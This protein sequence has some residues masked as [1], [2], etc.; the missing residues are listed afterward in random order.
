MNKYYILA[1]LAFSACA[2]LSAQPLSDRD[3]Q[4]QNTLARVYEETR[5]LGSAIRVYSELH[6]ARPQAADVSEALFRCLYSLKRY[7]EADTL[8]AERLVVEPKSFELYLNIARVKSKLNEKPAAIAAFSNALKFASENTFY[9]NS[10]TV[11]QVMLESGY[12]EEA[13]QTLIGQRDHADQPELFTDQIGGLYFRLGKYSDGV[14]EYLA[15]LRNN[16]QTLSLVEGRI[17][18]FT[19]D[20]LVR[21]QIIKEVTSHIEMEDAAGA[22]LRLLAWSYGEL[23]DYR[24]ALSIYLKLDDADVRNSSASAGGYELY[25]FA[26]RIRSEGALDVAVKA[27][28]EAVKRFRVGAGKDPQRKAFVAMAELGALLTKEDFLRQ[29]PEPPRDSLIAVVAELRKFAQDQPMPDLT[30]E[31]LLH[32]GE[33][34]FRLLNDF[35]TAQLIYENILAR[36]PGYTEKTRDAYFALE[37]LA[38]AQGD[39][40]LASIRLEVISDALSKRNR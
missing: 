13:L 16:P 25:T 21:R 29:M 30:I 6:H 10:V 34:S 8:L 27:Y 4:K 26:N 31:A 20:S 1:F 33:I 40:Q 39:L 38:L 9:Q 22:E 18:Q 12:Q 32:A 35:A 28:A 7:G 17:A 2:Q 5:D 36:S 24:H 37:E 23:K 3:F 19:A 11:S 15:M 14:K